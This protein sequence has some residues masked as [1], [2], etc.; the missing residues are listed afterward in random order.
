MERYPKPN[1]SE[2]AGVLDRRAEALLVD[3]VVVV[4]FVGGLAY[5]AGT[6]LGSGPMSGGLGMIVALQFAAPFLLLGY[7]IGFEGY[8]GQTI[9]K[10]SRGI[11]VVSDDGSSISWGGAILRNLLRI[12]D[13]LPILYI[14]GIVVAYI[15]DEHQRI[16]DLAGGTVVV[17]TQG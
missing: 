10:W 3:A 15:T 11:V 7:Q 12:V 4:A 6:F 9:G 17:N 14:V 1:M 2:R 16:G 8:Y 13:A 5:L